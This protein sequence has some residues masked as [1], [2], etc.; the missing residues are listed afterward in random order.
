[1][2]FIDPNTDP[3]QFSL[4][5]ETQP[6]APRLLLLDD[7]RELAP[8][9]PGWGLLLDNDVELAGLDLRPLRL[10]ALHFPKWTDGRAYTQA[11]LL[12]RRYGFRGEIRATGEVLVDM[13]PLLARSGFDSVVLSAGQDEAVARRNLGFFDSVPAPAA[14]YQG[15]VSDPRPLFARI[16]A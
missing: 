13:L 7:Y 6:S 3:W 5:D 9:T 4:D 16:P 11:W 15:D 2:K 10:I 14:Y 12:R 1:M 8:T